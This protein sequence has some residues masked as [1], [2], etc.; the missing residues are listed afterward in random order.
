MAYAEEYK[1][2]NERSNMKIQFNKSPYRIVRRAGEQ[3]ARAGVLVLAPDLEKL[4]TEPNKVI[5]N[6]IIAKEKL[7]KCKQICRISSFNVRTL[8]SQKQA[9]ELTA[10]AFQHGIDVICVQEHRLN[11]EDLNLKFHEMGNGWTFISASAWKN[12]G[13]S[14]IGGVGMLLSP[15]AQK[16]LMNI[17]KISSRIVIASFNGNP[18]TT[19]IS[20]YS[21]TNVCD[22]QEVDDFYNDLSSLVRTVPKH[23]VLILGG[24]LNAQL[25][26]NEYHKHAYHDE[27]NRN[28]EHLHHFLI[29][30]ELICLNTHY[31]KRK[32]KQWTHK[33]PNGVLAQLDFLIVNKKW[34]NS[35]HN[36]EAYSSFEGVLS[37]HRI[38]TAELQLSLRANRKN[39]ALRIPYEWSALSDSPDICAQFTIELTNRFESLQGRDGNTTADSTYKNFVSA[40]RE[41]A[42]ICIPRKPRQK[43]KVP[44]ENQ[45]VQNI[46]QKVQEMSK[47]KNHNPTRDNI[48][49][50]FE[51]QRELEDTYIQ[52]QQKYI[53]LQIDQI[54]AAH[55]NRRASLSWKIV[56]QLRGKTKPSQAK[57]K[58]NNR[59][60]RLMSWKAHFQNLLGN[61]PT[62]GQTQIVKIIHTELPIKKGPFI[63]AELEAVLRKLKNKKACGPDGIPPEVWKT[64]KFNDILLQL[65]NE[66][67][68]QNSIQ[69]WTEGCILPFPKKGD[70]G[71]ASNYRGITLTPIAAKMYNA[72]LLNRIRPEIEKHLRRNQNG[73]RKERSAI[74]QILTVRRIIEGVRAKNLEAV[75][76]FVDFYKAFDSVH[77]GKMKEILLAYGIP[78]ETV[79]AIMMLYKNTRAIVRSPDGDTDYFS[80]KA[81]VQQGDTLAPFLFIIT[82]DYVLRTS[83]DLNNNLGLTLTERRSRRH[84]AIKITDA[85]YADDLTLFADKIEDA[86]RLLHSLEAAA[87][88][89]GL[90]VNASETDYICYRQDGHIVTM[91]DS[92]L[93]K[94]EN[95]NYLGSNVGSTEKDIQIRIAKAWKAL[96]Y[97]TIIWKSSLP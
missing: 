8:Q 63:E 84:P 87:A 17:E 23:N 22:E 32:G 27:T 54:D 94:V 59:E 75:L 80:I 43:R 86:Q 28:G 24:D 38:I 78:T 95:F 58:A 81:G 4:A 93:K 34:I 64:G 74:G 48:R 31:R 41:A 11:H 37:D 97:L 56:D 61:A 69:H 45:S 36:C 35:A 51:S 68:N 82:L 76:L 44:W 52:E 55:T 85:D 29:E 88:D 92:H 7:L 26:K 20:C 46:R 14:T 40:H 70:L 57:L 30:N 21:P 9:S 1:T 73:F 39:D 5:A 42:E 6:K 62:I 47:I 15:N 66:V 18:H 16:T 77:R 33:Y 83:V 10:S 67:Y 49:K 72:M 90:H 53:Q 71:V 3:G 50:H 2:A 91:D 79:D 89:I 60:E 12:S 25:G 65:S 96:N 13:N 19:V